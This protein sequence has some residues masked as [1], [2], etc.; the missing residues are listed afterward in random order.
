VPT[1]TIEA[2]VSENGAKPKRT[3]RTAKPDVIDLTDS[4]PVKRGPGR[5]RKDGSAPQKATTARKRVAKAPVAEAPV[6]VKRGP[7]RPRK[8]GSPPVPSAPKRGDKA[9][10]ARKVIEAKDR[11]I[12]KARAKAA[13]PKITVNGDTRATDN[14]FRIGCNSYIY[15][16]MLK[17]GGKRS[18]LIRRIK[19]KVQLHPWTKSEADIDVDYEIDQRLILVANKLSN[20]GWKVEKGGRGRESTIKVYPPSRR[21]A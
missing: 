17:Q 1:A 18:A 10:A 11:A 16:E 4:A 8:D 2:P 7:G 9:K 14:P 19:S 12:V 15:T 21:K 5:P 13:V 20:L 3:R 6:V